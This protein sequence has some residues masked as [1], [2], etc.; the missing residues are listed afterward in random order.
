M[1]KLGR[2]RRHLTVPM[3]V[4]LL[5]V[6]PLCAAACGGHAEAMPF[7]GQAET[8]HAPDCHDMA[9]P[10]EADHGVSVSDCCDEDASTL[11][12]ERAQSLPD[13]VVVFASDVP[14]P[15]ALHLTPRNFFTP[16][17]GGRS[18]GRQLLLL[19]L[20]FLE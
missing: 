2:Q 16:S 7:A 17:P 11:Q 6:A 9:P 8:E 14:D 3:A 4:L 15:F 18:P 10:E 13:P 19:I 12:A 1:H 20:A 5:L